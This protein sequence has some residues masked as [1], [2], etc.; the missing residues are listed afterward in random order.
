MLV[1]PLPVFS[2]SLFFS[3]PIAVE[4]RSLL[5]LSSFS[6]GSPFVGVLCRS[7]LRAACA[8]SRVPARPHSPICRHVTNLVPARAHDPVLTRS[9]TTSGPRRAQRT[10]PVPSFPFS[11]LAP[12]RSAL[13]SA[14]LSSSLVGTRHTHSCDR[15]PRTRCALPDVVWFGLYWIVGESSDGSAATAASSMI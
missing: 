5:S 15:C 2:L 10:L 9:R 14:L 8:Q 7:S 3:F 11:F 1:V 6:F 12:R 13:G 4:P